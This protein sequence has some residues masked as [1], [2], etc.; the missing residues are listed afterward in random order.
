MTVFQI[1]PM[2]DKITTNILKVYWK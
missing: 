2:L 1:Y